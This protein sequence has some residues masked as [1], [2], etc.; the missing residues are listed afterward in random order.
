MANEGKPVSQTKT[1]VEAASWKQTSLFRSFRGQV[2]QVP[3]H[4]ARYTEMTCPAQSN[5]RI[6][7]SKAGLTRGAEDIDISGEPYL[8]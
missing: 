3:F 1:R 5:F 4:Q 8:K 7:T 2:V 6:K